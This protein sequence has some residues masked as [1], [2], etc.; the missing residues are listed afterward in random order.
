M[1][2]LTQS[3]NFPEGTVSVKFLFT[4]AVPAEVAYLDG[5]PSYE[6]I[7]DAAGTGGMNPPPPVESR[8]KRTVHLLQVD[9]SVKDADAAATGWIFGTFG[10]VGPTTGDGLFDNLM[11]VSLQWGNDPEIYDQAITQSW[12]NPDLHMK[13]Y[14]WNQRPTLGFNGRANG[15]ADNIRS[16]CLSCHAAARTPRS[17]LGIVGFAFNMANIGDPAKVKQHVDVW[18]DNVKSGSL[19][20]PD[21]PAVSALDYSLQVEAAIYRMCRACRLGDLPGDTPPVCIA[22]SFYA[23]P[24]CSPGIMPLDAAGNVL[25]EQMQADPPPRQ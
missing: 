1:P 18:F 19:F 10:W 21:E 5:A 6:A 13:M 7:I 11:P 14:G 22:A 12:I 25:R 8:Q 15:P 3:L 16:S 2:S 4:D 24:Q 20:R 17:S 9:I 23:P